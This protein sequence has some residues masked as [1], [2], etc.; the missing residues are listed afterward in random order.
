MNQ[1]LKEKIKYLSRK[2]FGYDPSLRKITISEDF[3][4]QKKILIDNN[5][6]A[7]TIFDIGAN[8]GQTTQKYRKLFPKSII[9]GFEPFPKVFEIYSKNTN[10]EKKIHKKQFALSNKIGKAFFFSNE[11]HYTNSLLAIDKK[12]GNDNAYK[13]KSKIEIETNTL[14]NFCKENN[15]KRINI[16]K[17]D[18]QGGEMLV[19]EGAKEMLSQKAIDLIYT[20]I[21]FVTLYQDQP[22]FEDIRKFLNNYGYKFY[23]NYNTYYNEKSEAISAD[24]IFINQRLTLK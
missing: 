1:I 19:L 4:E 23:K 3:I 2:Y 13:L 9:Y 6:K 21:E 5:V 15:I 8:V 14:D 20:E 17:M 18:V 11:N 16:L 7:E 10:G 12:F 22:L 24:S